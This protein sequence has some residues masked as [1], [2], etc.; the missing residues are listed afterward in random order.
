MFL[1]FTE[2]DSEDNEPE[3][4]EDDMGNEEDVTNV[5]KES[6]LWPDCFEE[7]SSA[8]SFTIAVSKSLREGNFSLPTLPLPE[9]PS[10]EKPEPIEA[11]T[12]N[13][14]YSKY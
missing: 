14:P 3:K 12:C 5:A 10:E 8:M 7:S 2:K 4:A 9:L 1:Y 11:S 6:T 13:G